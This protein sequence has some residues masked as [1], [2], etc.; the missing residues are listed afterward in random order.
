MKYGCLVFGKE[1]FLKVKRYQQKN[2][3]LEDYMHKNT[4]DILESNMSDAMILDSDDVPSD[5]I[6]LHSKVTVTCES[7]WQETFRLVPPAKENIKNN[8]ISVVSSLGA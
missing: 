2:S 6:Q 8:R 1:D 7:R 3:T 4:L 5:V